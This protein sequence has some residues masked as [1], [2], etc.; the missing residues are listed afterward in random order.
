MTGEVLDTAKHPISNLPKRKHWNAE[1]GYA[2][3]KEMTRK[4]STCGTF[5][6]AAPI[7]ECRNAPRNAGF[8]SHRELLRTIE[9]ETFARVC[10]GELESFKCHHWSRLHHLHFVLPF[11]LFPFSG[12][13]PPLLLVG[14]IG[15]RAEEARG[16]KRGKLKKPLFLFTSPAYLSSCFENPDIRYGSR[17]DR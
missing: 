1:F 16:V 13:S 12:P 2:A 4:L 9:Q 5:L 10:E 15:N 14:F 11:C 7:M 17:H 8:F 6:Q 3:I